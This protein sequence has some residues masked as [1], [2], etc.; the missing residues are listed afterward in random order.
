MHTHIHAYTHTCIHTYMHTHMHTYMHT[1]IHAYIKHH[2]HTPSHTY[3]HTHIQ[4]QRVVQLPSLTPCKGCPPVPRPGRLE[5]EKLL[6]AVAEVVG[7][8]LA[9]E[10]LHQTAEIVFDSLHRLFDDG[11]PSKTLLLHSK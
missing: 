4:I 6:H 8:E 10:D 7:G 2:R 1:H 5:Y 9:S 3:T 11:P